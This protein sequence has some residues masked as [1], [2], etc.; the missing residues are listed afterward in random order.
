[1]LDAEAMLLQPA[2]R[3]GNELIEVSEGSPSVLRGQV[4][5]R[6]V[7]HGSLSLRTA[8]LRS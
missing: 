5:P 4:D 3:L 8:G 7:G 1:M 2:L 6:D